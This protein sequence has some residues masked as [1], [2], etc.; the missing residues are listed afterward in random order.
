MRVVRLIL[1]A[2][3]AIL[4]AAPGVARADTS[5]EEREAR[6]LSLRDEL[7]QLPDDIDVAIVVR[8]LSRLR[9]TDA[10]ALASGAMVDPAFDEV[11]AR[12][13]ALSDAIGLDALAAF[14]A[15]LGDRVILAART[16]A[17]GVADWTLWT[18]VSSRTEWLLRKQLKV[19]PRTIVAGQ[20]LYTVERGALDL[21]FTRPC[22]DCPGI[23][24][25]ILAPSGSALFE[26]AVRGGRRVEG[27]PSHRFVTEFLAEN[28]DADAAMIARLPKRENAWVSMGATVRGEEISVSVRTSS[29][30][31][32]PVG[33]KARLL[34]G[35]NERAVSSIARDA[36]V[37]IFD[38]GGSALSEAAS[39]VEPLFPRGMLAPDAADAEGVLSGREVAM[40]MPTETG[41]VALL[42][43]VEL[44]D[45]ER[46]A[47]LG[48]TAMDTML[49]S[50]GVRPRNFSGVLPS[51]VRSV[52]ESG[53]SLSWVYRASSASEPAAPVGVRTPTPGWWMMTTDPGLFDDAT[54][55]LSTA[56][57]EGQGV[58]ACDGA[59]GAP[60]APGRF[61]DGQPG[62]GRRGASSA[63]A[64][65][66]A[67]PSRLVETLER[68][69]VTTLPAL[70]GLRAVREVRWRELGVEGGVMRAEITVLLDEGAA[71]PKASR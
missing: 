29:P 21:T 46:G 26:R 16:P 68:T 69:G 36:I 49:E 47:V 40:L 2:F 11:R 64:F 17:G 4:V 10:G 7:A 65:A 35:W 1:I 15:V 23:A 58:G 13:G 6:R 30:D 25:L 38:S 55:R 33:T 60:G 53:V 71:A 34:R 18:D 54:A 5:G 63:R 8:G 61:S 62:E 27:A 44:L 48:D 14:D 66:V 56:A 37:A 67:R 52:E 39:L 70:A 51:A 19:S 22:A 32:D 12:W 3:A 41:G 45:L 31:A 42:A 28:P 43:V 20:T 57:L 9:A 59:S 24:R 50:F